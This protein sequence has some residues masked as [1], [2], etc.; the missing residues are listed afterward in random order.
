MPTAFVDPNN[1]SV[2]YL[3]IDDSTARREPANRAKY[4]AM[5]AMAAGAVGLGMTSWQMTPKQEKEKP[6]RIANAE[7]LE[8]MRLSREAEEERKQRPRDYYFSHQQQLQER[9]GDI[10]YRDWH[11]AERPPG[12]PPVPYYVARPGFKYM[13]PQERA[14]YGSE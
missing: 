6:L 10:F 2:V 12:W 14:E 1:P 8:N 3:P 7:T 13:R 5:S 9:Q 11:H 4:A